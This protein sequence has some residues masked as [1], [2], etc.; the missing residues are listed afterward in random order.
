MHIEDRDGNK[1]LD[2]F[3]GL[4]CVNVCYGR[5][6]IAEAIAD[7]ARSWLTITPML[8]MAPRPRSPYSR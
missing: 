7:Q 5:Q 6:E 3:V 1:L 4:Y 8:V 2:A